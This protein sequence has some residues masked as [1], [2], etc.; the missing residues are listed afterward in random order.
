MP[1]LFFAVGSG[2]L[3]LVWALFGGRGRRSADPAP[4]AE[5]EEAGAA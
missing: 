3:L 2:V 4:A 1:R 5:A